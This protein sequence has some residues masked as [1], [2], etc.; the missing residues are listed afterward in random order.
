MQDKTKRAVGRPLSH[1]E[2]D[3]A[4]DTYSVRLPARLARFAR[5]IG[6]NNL[7]EGIRY[8]LAYALIQGLVGQ[9]IISLAEK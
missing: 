8:A 3:L 7:S 4:L 1:P 6:N 5:K 9:T 2:Q